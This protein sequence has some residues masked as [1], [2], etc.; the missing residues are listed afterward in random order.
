M[1]LETISIKMGLDT[2]VDWVFNEM[3]DLSTNISYAIIFLTVFTI[4]L[5]Y[6]PRLIFCVK[7]SKCRFKEGYPAKPFEGGLIVSQHFYK[8]ITN[9][10]VALPMLLSIECIVTVFLFTGFSS[11]ALISFLLGF[12]VYVLIAILSI[13]GV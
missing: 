12:T 2:R 8:Y 9:I 1:Y 6:L 7:G 3:T 10:T 13:E 11:Y 4:A 5:F